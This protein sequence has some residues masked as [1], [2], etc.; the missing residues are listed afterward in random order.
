MIKRIILM[1][2]LM[3][4]L[5]FASGYMV[6]RSVLTTKMDSAVAQCT[7]EVASGCPLL[8]HYV[9]DL[10]RENTRLNV[11]LNLFVGDIQS[12]LTQPDTGKVSE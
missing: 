9:S 4:A 12:R 11:A 3:L 8:Y 10:E 7:A 6:T 2:M 1:M 5:G